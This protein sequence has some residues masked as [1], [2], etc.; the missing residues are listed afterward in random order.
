MRIAASQINN[1]SDLDELTRAVE[2][3]KTCLKR[4]GTESK[5][6]KQFATFMGE[7]RDWLDSAHGQ[8]EDFSEKQESLADLVLEVRNVSRIF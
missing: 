2:N 3:Y 8:S 7:W 4:E 5:Y 6:I 1:R